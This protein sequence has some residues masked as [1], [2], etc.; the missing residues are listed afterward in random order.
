MATVCVL[1]FLQ[2][3]RVVFLVF[4]WVFV[5]CPAALVLLF[6]LWSYLSRESDSNSGTLWSPPLPVLLHFEALL[7]SHLS[8]GQFAWALWG[9]IPGFLRWHYGHFM[10]SNSQQMQM[11]KRWLSSTQMACWLHHMHM[12]QCDISLGDS[13][14][15]LPYYWGGCFLGGYTRLTWCGCFQNHLKVLRVDAYSPI[16][17]MM[18]KKSP[19]QRVWQSKWPNWLPVK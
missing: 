11:T 12:I 14:E 1:F 15:W 5:N 6:L 4:V 19:K 18:K 10:I 8:L 9:Q 7:F 13:L 16:L 17:L 2:V 3:V